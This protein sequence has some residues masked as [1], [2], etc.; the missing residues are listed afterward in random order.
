MERSILLKEPLQYPL[1]IALHHAR[2]LA[3]LSQVEL[4]EHA[5]VS[6]PTVRNLEHGR[7]NLTS[8]LK[9]LHALGLAVQGRNLPP[10][11][12]LG[13]QLTL[14]RQRRGLS[15]RTLCSLIGCS[16]PT[17]ISLETQ[18]RGRLKTLSRALIVLGAGVYLAPPEHKQPFYTH[19]GNRS[20]HHGWETPQTLLECL[21]RVFQFDLDPCSPTRHRRSAPVKATMHY[22]VQDDGLSLPWYGTVFVNPPYG[23]DL[24]DWIAKAHTEVRHGNTQTVVALVPARTDTHYWHEHIAGHATVFFLRGRLRFGNSKQSAPFPSALVIWGSTEEQRQQL[25]AILTDAWQVNEKL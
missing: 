17:L 16:Q 4:A 15:Q 5:S 1:G 10:G 18:D 24:P 11:D 20:V 22:T 8:W 12:T 7:G 6:I 3:H 13:Q 19:V 9:V 2:K 14:L 25:A 21:Y 23:R